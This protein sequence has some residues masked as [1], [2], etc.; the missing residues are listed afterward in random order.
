MAF[1]AKLRRIG[2]SVGVILPKDVITVN[3][4]V[5]TKTKHKGV[6]YK[7]RQVQTILDDS[8]ALCR[9]CGQQGCVGLQCQANRKLKGVTQQA[10]DGSIG[11]CEINRVSLPGDVDYEGVVSRSKYWQQVKGPKPEVW[12]PAAEPSP[13]R[14]RH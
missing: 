7:A 5:I 2:N 8:A 11:P 13:R 4:N 10:K 12:L 9:Y 6:T 14:S 1:K 3:E